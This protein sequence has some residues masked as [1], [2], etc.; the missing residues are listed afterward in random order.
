MSS[1]P[2]ANVD[3]IQRLVRQI[4]SQQASSL[5]QQALQPTTDPQ[6]QS[7]NSTGNSTLQEELYARFRIPRSGETTV[8]SAPVQQQSSSPQLQLANAFDPAVNHA[9]RRQMRVVPYQRPARQPRGRSTSTITKP[10]TPKSDQF[11]KDVF[12]LPCNDWEKVPRGAERAKL[13]RIGLYRDAVSFE[14]E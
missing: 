2:G 1:T 3:E 5:S 8:A 14:K 11:K 7:S 12:L 10:S 9:R 4:V 13:H 6:R